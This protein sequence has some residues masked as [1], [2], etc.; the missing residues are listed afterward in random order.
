MKDCSPISLTFQ[1]IWD[2]SVLFYASGEID[3]TAHYIS[4]SILDRKVHVHLDFGH[5]S[6]ISTILGEDVAN[7][8]WRNFTIFHND[9]KV[10][11]SLD[12][13]LVP[14]DIPG[15]NHYMIIDPEIYIGGGP[16]PHKKRGLDSF[17]NFAGSLKYVFFNDKS[18]IY[19]LK[20]SNP[21]VHYIGVL[22]PEYYDTDV[23][24]IPITYPFAGSHIWWPIKRKDSLVLS[25]EFQSSKPVA[26]LAS[27]DVNMAQST[28]YWEV[29]LVDDQV[30][31]QLIPLLTENITVK[32]DVD[33][34]TSW[35]KVELNY[36]R[37]RI[38][39]I[40]DYHHLQVKQLPRPF[41]L[42]DRVI[43]GS[44]KSD[45]GLVGCMR[46]IRVNSDVIEPR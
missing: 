46:D 15:D 6:R 34:T 36:T 26:V 14:L 22:E 7:N 39:L 3:G 38:S 2:D 11:I 41:E 21:M 17:N 32:A 18:I 35:H 30:W 1:T 24:V 25:F 31:F 10:F 4:A 43:I 13:E 9:S 33:N 8:N 40:V 37:G 20:K 28:G 19:E 42:T 5:N 23:K 45:A 12:E 27:G 44:G 29:G 16:E